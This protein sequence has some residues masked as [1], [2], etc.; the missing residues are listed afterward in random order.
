MHNSL[1]LQQYI[2]YTTLLNMFR[3]ARC[4]KHVEECS[5]TY[6]LLK[7]QRIVHYV[8]I[9]KSLYYDARSEKHQ[10]MSS[11]ISAII[12]LYHI[13]I[14]VSNYVFSSRVP[15]QYLFIHFLMYS[16]FFGRLIIPNF[17]T[18]LF[19]IKYTLLL[20]FTLCMQLAVLLWSSYPL[21]HLLLGHL[22]IL[23]GLRHCTE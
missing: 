21:H 8:G 23:F 10:I 17:I 11:V 6:V 9:L 14:R 22:Q 4:S 5:V 15:V 18:S 19:I 20:I 7:I 2:C 3:A 1:N 16:T 12:S 13:W